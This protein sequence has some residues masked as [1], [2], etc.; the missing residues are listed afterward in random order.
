MCTEGG[1]QIYRGW[2]LHTEVALD[3]RFHSVTHTVQ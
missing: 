3:L 1:V 2:W